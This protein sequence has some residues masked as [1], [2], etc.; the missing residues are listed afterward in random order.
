MLRSI[1][2]LLLAGIVGWLSFDATVAQTADLARSKPPQ[3]R[4]DGLLQT[5]AAG[6]KLEG[7]ASDL[8]PALIAIVESG[9]IQESELAMR[10]LAKM[11]SKAS[12]AIAVI[13]KKLGDSTHA[14]RSAAVDALVAI[15][16]RCVVPVR[17]LLNLPTARTRASAAEVL[18]R[19]KKLDLA[20]FTIL[21]KDAD[22]RVRAVAANGL[23][24]FGKPGVP[25]LAHML[26]DPDLAVSVEAARALK[27]N[28]KDASIAIPRLTTAL[29]RADLTR[30][31]AEALAAYGVEARSAI[32]AIIKAQAL[33]RGRFYFL[34][35]AE[36]A[37]QH[38]G[39]PREADIPQLC[40]SLARDEET[41]IV[42]AKCLGLLG[43]NGKP[44]AN[45]LEAAAENSIKEYVRLM[46]Q[47]GWD[48]SGRVFL[49]GEYCAAALW[50]VTHDAPRFLRLIEKLAIAA[51]RPVRYARPSLL[52]D[53]S[54]GDCHL[55]EL[56][57]RHANTN[58]QQTAL[59]V[60]FDLGPKAAPL[61]KVVLELAKGRNAELTRKAIRTL[62]AIGPGAGNEAAPVLLSRLSDGALPLQEFAEAAGR[63]QIRLKAAQAILERGLHDK[64]RW[65]AVSCATA[66]CNTS[67]EPRR[68]ARLII[69][70]IQG[71]PIECRDAIATLKRLKAA[72]DVVIPFLALQLQSDDY[73]T[74]Y[75]A[76]TAL[77]SFGRKAHQTITPLKKLLADESQLIR[78]KAAQAL[79]QISSIA[80]ELAKELQVIFARDDIPDRFK[81]LQTIAELHRSGGRFV[82]YA[83]TELRRSPPVLAE[84]AMDALQ[85]IGTDEAVAALRATAESTDW[86]L[87]SQATK[88]LQRVA[89]GKGGK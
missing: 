48:N 71:G 27:S 35:V 6:G 78:L 43:L 64:D 52:A 83:L 14:T 72:D 24:M 21:R 87:R 66:L 36:Q 53:V 44:A 28:R 10:V 40:E 88:A 82:G 54:P 81:A 49:A 80:T 89:D 29:S 74:R 55:I 9:E 31:V 59:D 32:P 11:G 73:W 65:T 15:G 19:L 23:S 20:D 22:P 26:Q 5:I 18:S 1:R 30:D 45:A 47:P 56:M 8:I 76:I 62:G 50:D 25:Q 85:A 7:D 79:F 38:I 61:K 3:N 63:L 67:S 4:V 37:L 84:E 17:K 70:A 13:S 39:P 34:D 41:R 2:P 42:V 77:G 75:D 60:L 12:P 16:D 58:V 46:R 69:D 86:R 68:P 33:A 57:L 51:N